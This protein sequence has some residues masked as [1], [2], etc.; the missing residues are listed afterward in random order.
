[1]AGG[2]KDFG[3]YCEAES[4]VNAGVLG[5]TNAGTVAVDLGLCRNAWLTINQTIVTDV[6]TTVLIEHSPDN[7]TFTTHTTIANADLAATTLA[8]YDLYNLYR[9]VRLSWVRAAANA[10]SFWSVVII[11]D[12]MIR[13]PTGT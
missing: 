10:D 3:S 13:A 4:V 12:L 2:I 6:P 8:T 5:V 11:G 7:V 1:M 9:Y